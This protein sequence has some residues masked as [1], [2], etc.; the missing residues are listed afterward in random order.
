MK[1]NPGFLSIVAP[2]E[3]IIVIS[4]SEDHIS[5][6]MFHGNSYSY[7]SRIRADVLERLTKSYINAD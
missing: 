4:L 5:A 7:A 2:N 6:F 1:I 3:I